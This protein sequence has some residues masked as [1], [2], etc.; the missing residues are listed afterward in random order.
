ME[1]ILSADLNTMGSPDKYRVVFY[2]EQKKG[3]TWLVDFTPS[4]YI[5]RLDFDLGLPM[6]LCLVIECV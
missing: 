5:A 6:K 3:S 4:V 2:T 1:D